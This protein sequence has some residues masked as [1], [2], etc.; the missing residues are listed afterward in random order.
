MPIVFKGV[1]QLSCAYVFP[2]DIKPKAFEIIIKKIQLFK[3][4]FNSYLSLRL[5]DSRTCLLSMGG[6]PPPSPGYLDPKRAQ[7]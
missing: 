5:P 4:I 6:P 3:N 2:F 7:P 1:S